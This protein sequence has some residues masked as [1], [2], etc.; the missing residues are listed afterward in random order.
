LQQN[1]Y[2]KKIFSLEDLHLQYTQVRVDPI[3]KDYIARF[4]T[5]LR[6]EYTR[7]EVVKN[8]IAS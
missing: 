8:K 3:L 2:E 6:P 4:T 1:S 5:Q 7:F